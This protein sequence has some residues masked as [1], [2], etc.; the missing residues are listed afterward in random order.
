[1]VKGVADTTCI[2][3]YYFGDKQY[4]KDTAEIDANGSFLF[5]GSETLKRRYLYDCFS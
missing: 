5:E 1:M 2:L 3:A 4:A